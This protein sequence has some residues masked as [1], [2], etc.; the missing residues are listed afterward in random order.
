MIWKRLSR[1]IF[2]YDKRLQNKIFSKIDKF[3][4]KDILKSFLS[5]QIRT[6]SQEFEFDQRYRYLTHLSQQFI[7]KRM[8][9]Y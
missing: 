6:R 7:P 3:F 5:K 2:K 8:I 1:K 4:R 9:I